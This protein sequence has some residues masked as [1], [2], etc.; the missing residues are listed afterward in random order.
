V[1]FLRIPS[2]AI[3]HAAYILAKDTN[4]LLNLKLKHEL[5]FI[6]FPRRAAI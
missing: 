3:N 5:N 4:N 1:A 2:I 6:H